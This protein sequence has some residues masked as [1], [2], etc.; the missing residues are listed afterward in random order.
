MDRFVIR[1]P[2][3]SIHA[4]SESIVSNVPTE[5]ASNEPNVRKEAVD[6]NT[7]QCHPIGVEGSSTRIRR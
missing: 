1:L 7:K 6:T 4:N 2:H 5:P 3:T